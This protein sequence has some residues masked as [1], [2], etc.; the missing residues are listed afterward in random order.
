MVEDAEQDDM[1]LELGNATK[2]FGDANPS[3]AVDI[4]FFCLRIEEAAIVPHGGAITRNGRQTMGECFELLFRIKGQRFFGP[5]GHV[6]VRQFVLADVFSKTL[7]NGN[8]TFGIQT[9]RV[10]SAEGHS[11]PLYP[12]RRH[13]G[14]NLSADRC[15]SSP[16]SMM[17]AAA[18]HTLF[19]GADGV[20]NWRFSD[21]KKRSVE[22]S[23]EV[24]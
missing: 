16:N 8:A 7:W 3:L 20:G 14:Q 15:R 13:L 22:E 24:G 10:S 11:S 1:L 17:C 23:Q 9:S 18:R 5:G 2:S 12:T 4:D 6:Q 21:F 19:L